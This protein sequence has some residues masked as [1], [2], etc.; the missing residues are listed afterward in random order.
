MRVCPELNTEYL[1]DNPDIVEILREHV[2]CPFLK[3]ENKM[4]NICDICT[5]I[6]GENFSDDEYGEK[7]GC[8]C[9]CFVYEP[10]SL[11]AAI[12]LALSEL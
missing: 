7:S 5:A 8:P 2:K 9:P 1:G 3:Y 6:F 10:K 12:R 4:G 11:D